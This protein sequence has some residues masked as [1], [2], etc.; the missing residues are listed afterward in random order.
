VLLELRLRDGLE[1]DVL[2]ASGREAV[3]G[4]VDRGLALVEEDRLVLTRDGRLLADGVVRE[5]L[6]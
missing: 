4:V 1:L 3:P 2:D 5:L 6:P